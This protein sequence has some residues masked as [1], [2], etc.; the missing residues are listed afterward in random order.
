MRALFIVVRV[1]GA[2]L[3]VAAMV[4]QMIRSVQVWTAAGV[5]DLSSLVA[6]FFSFFTIDSN[7]LSVVSFA[8][9]AVLLI[10]GRREGVNWSLFRGCVTAYMATTGIVYNTL[11]RGVELPQGTT[12]LWSNEVLHVIAPVLVVADWLLAPG[13]NRLEWKHIGWVVAFPLVWTVYTMIRGP[14]VFDEIAKRPYW[15][16]YPFL[17]PNTAPEGY[18]SVFF[19][20]VLIAAVIGGVG[21]LAIRVSRMGDRWPL[22]AAG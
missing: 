10:A 4:A 7:V 18:V 8:V 14:L 21:A 16:P 19:Y 6:N 5:E 12:V 9:G 20:M 11:L 3:I 2:V 1:V 15:Y 17:N 22:R 13:R